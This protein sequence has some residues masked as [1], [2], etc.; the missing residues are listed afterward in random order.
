MK[1][2][3]GGRIKNGRLMIS[4]KSY[5]EN[6]IGQ[7]PDSD[8]IVTVEILQGDASK[9]SLAYFKKV[10]IPEMQKAFFNAGERYTLKKTEE[11]CLGMCPDAHT[12]KY[13]GR[14]IR[15]LI[16]PEAM[17]QKQLNSVIEHLKEIA[18]KHFNH[19]I[20]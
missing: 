19:F 2:T 9:R 4:N 12:E 3:V 16:M 18:A 14:W 5:F 6:T 15:E 1:I 11:L 20:P 8:V 17:S 13:E 7:N 10:I